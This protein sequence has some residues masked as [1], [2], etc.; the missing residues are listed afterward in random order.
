MASRNGSACALFADRRLDRRVSRSWGPGPRAI[1]QQD[2]GTM[3]SGAAGF[4]DSSRMFVALLVQLIV[5]STGP[6]RPTIVCCRHVRASSLPRIRLPHV[7]TVSSCGARGEMEF[8]LPIADEDSPQDQVTARSRRRDRLVS[9]MLDC[10]S[11][12]RRSKQ[13]DGRV[14]DATSGSTRVATGHASGQ[15]PC[16]RGG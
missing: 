8:G 11:S 5:D 12:R 2:A 16:V 3:S 9:G 13:E 10:T 15:G 4:V 7:P 1:V 6:L 14:I